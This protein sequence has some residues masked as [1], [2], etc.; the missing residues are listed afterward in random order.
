MTKNGKIASVIAAIALG[1]AVFATPVFAKGTVITLSTS[2][3]AS[4]DEYLSL[5][6]DAPEAATA[7]FVAHGANA[8][9]IGLDPASMT[10]ADRD[11]IR[12]IYSCDDDPDYYDAVNSIVYAAL[13]TYLEKGKAET[14]TTSI[15]PCT[16]TVTYNG[17][18]WY[19][20]GDAL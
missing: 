14:V 15:G 17:P 10:K 13:Q 6:V 11:K 12:A 20:D 7:F 1:T 19:E 8:K 9:T 3:S 4:N 5:K 18:S 16:W 2:V